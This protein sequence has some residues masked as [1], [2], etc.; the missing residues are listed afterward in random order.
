ME[1]PSVYNILLMHLLLDQLLNYFS[2]EYL[3]QKSNLSKSVGHKNET[4]QI[5]L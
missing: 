4:S 2:H 5:K 1:I 3:G